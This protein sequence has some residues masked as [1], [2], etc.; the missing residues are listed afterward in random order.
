MDSTEVAVKLEA[1]GHEIESLK[2][3]VKELEQQSGVVQELTISMN[4]IA[5]RIENLATETNQH[6]KR[7]EVLEKVPVETMRMLKTTIITAIIS[8]AVGAVLSAIMSVT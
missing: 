4:R 6:G 3:R 2:H 5:V 7:L 8:G 1:H